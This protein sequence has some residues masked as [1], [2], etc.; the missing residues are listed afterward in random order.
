MKED[1]GVV[2]VREDSGGAFNEL[3]SLDNVDEEPDGCGVMLGE[4]LVN[5]FRVLDV[6]TSCLNK[7]L[8]FYFF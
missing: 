5:I 3:G 7:G 1:T 6:E 8:V 2:G 4:S